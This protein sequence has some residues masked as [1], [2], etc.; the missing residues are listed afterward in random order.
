MSLHSLSKKWIESKGEDVYASVEEFAEEVSSAQ[1]P[2]A[3]IADQIEC[4]W[5]AET[6]GALAL[7]LVR[8]TRPKRTGWQSS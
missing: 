1:W 6:R 4:G 2:Y 8:T 3:I 5:T 7:N